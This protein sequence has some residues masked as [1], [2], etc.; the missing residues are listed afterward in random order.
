M[1]ANDAPLIDTV[2]PRDPEIE[3]AAL[4]AMLLDPDALAV[5]LRELRREDFTVPEHADLFRLI[6]EVAPDL[7]AD[8]RLDI[9]TVCNALRVAGLYDRIGGKAY[10]VTLV[11]SCPAP[12]N[13]RAYAKILRDKAALRRV[14]NAAAEVQRMAS[15]PDAD[16]EAAL[17]P[18]LAAQAEVARR[19]A[20]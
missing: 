3:A 12:S 17:K 20:S 11:D 6:V 19:E 15:R 8:E 14:I 2:P 16:P 7:Q 1:T 13:I 18:L 9:V 4:G 5:G 10:L